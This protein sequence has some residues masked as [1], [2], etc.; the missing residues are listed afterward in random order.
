MKFDND[1]VI[2]TDEIWYETEKE[3]LGFETV[4]RVSPSAA[5]LHLC[6]GKNIFKI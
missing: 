2:N 5:F 6:G 3:V 1:E 4:E